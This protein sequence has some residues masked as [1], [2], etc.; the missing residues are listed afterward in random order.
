[1]AGLG[2]ACS[3]IA[4]LLFAVEAN[5]QTNKRHTYS[6]RGSTQLAFTLLKYRKASDFALIVE[7]RKKHLYSKNTRIHVTQ[8][9][10][11]ISFIS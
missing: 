1:M 2:E 8:D 7:K 3:H 11:M 10:I 6:A 5:N 4:A 9:Y